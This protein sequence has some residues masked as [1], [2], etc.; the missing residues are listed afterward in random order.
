MNSQFKKNQIIPVTRCVAGV[1]WLLLNSFSITSW[2]TS[3]VHR[4]LED[5]SM[6]SRNRQAYQGFQPTLSSNVGRY[7]LKPHTSW[8]C[9]VNGPWSHTSILVCL[10][11]DREKLSLC[12]A[13]DGYWQPA[14]SL[15]DETVQPL[16]TQHFLLPSIFQ[17]T[18]RTSGM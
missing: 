17:H 10:S 7:W 13:A 15:S 9:I 3:L 6:K 11:G 16:N 14:S 2:V 4:Y 8:D 5:A 12:L 1:A 18:L